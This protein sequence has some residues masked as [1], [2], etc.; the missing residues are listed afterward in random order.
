[1]KV[2]DLQDLFDARLH[3]LY[4]NTPAMFK[5]DSETK[6]NLQAF[7]KRFMLKNFTL[8]IYNDTSEEE[9]IANFAK[10]VKADMI[11]LRTHGRKGIARLASGS[12]A[13]DVVNHINCPIWTCRIKA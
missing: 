12:I 10:D 9:G 7:A 11:A 2:K 4:V 5:K 8:N 13:E 1:M 6:A 3:V